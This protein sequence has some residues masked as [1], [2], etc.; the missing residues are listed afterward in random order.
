MATNRFYSKTNAETQLLGYIAWQWDRYLVPQNVFLVIYK[1]ALAGRYS[2]AEVMLFKI[3]VQTSGTAFV[4]E[5]PSCILSAVTRR[6]P[7]I[8][9]NTCR[10]CV[11]E[12]KRVVERFS[13]CRS[14]VPTLVA[15]DLLSLWKVILWWK[16]WFWPAYDWFSS[17]WTLFRLLWRWRPLAK[18]LLTSWSSFVWSSFSLAPAPAP[19]SPAPAHVTTDNRI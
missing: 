9:C 11:P 2:M 6:T 4:H 14:R 17:L 19:S 13:A 15:L 8:R 16:F 18:L 1:S 5:P 10:S 12:D 3:P 7:C